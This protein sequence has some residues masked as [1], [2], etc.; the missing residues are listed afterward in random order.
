MSS[1]FRSFSF[2]TLS[3]KVELFFFFMNTDYLYNH[4]A[5]KK[6]MAFVHTIGISAK[7]TKI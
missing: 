7:D 5:L 4:K 2:V 1:P 6:T 3:E